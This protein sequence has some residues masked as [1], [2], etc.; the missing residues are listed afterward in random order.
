MVII[1]TPFYIFGD[2]FSSYSGFLKTIMYRRPFRGYYSVQR[3]FNKQVRQLPG[4]DHHNFNNARPYTIAMEIQDRPEQARRVHI[5]YTND[6][7]EAEAWLRN[8]VIDLGS[9][10]LGFDI[11]CKP[12][13]VKK[14]LGGKENKTAVLQ[15]STEV[16]VL[17]LH[18]KHV[19][20]LPRH[21]A[22]ILANHSILKVGCGIR[23]D[24]IKLLKDTRLQCKGAIDL[25]DVASKSGYTKQH[26]LGLKNLAKNLLGIEMA[27]PKQ[28]QLSN[29]EILPLRESQIHYAAL[30]AWVGIKLY[31]H[32]HNKMLNDCKNAKSEIDGLIDVSPS[33]IVLMVCNVCG[34]KCKGQKKFE[35]HMANAGHTQCTKCGKMFVFTVTRKHRNS[36]VGAEGQCTQSSA[37][38]VNTQSFTHFN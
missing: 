36:C 10:A 38:A 16:S 22:E 34:K 25:V 14:K 2:E 24:V 15:L 33:G 9:T 12:Q 29:W 28:I 6:P 27:K 23:H 17:V 13:F 1:V 18:I 32:M 30:D 5:T 37:S 26:G 3:N 31:S 7:I 20:T 21:L 35:E 4:Q 8:N 19:Q 11:E